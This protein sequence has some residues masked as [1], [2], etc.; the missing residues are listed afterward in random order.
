MF[1][2]TSRIE[3]DNGI[4]FYE[5]DV[6]FDD[7][8][9]NDDI[10]IELTLDYI[11]NGFGI[12]FI[13]SENSSLQ[14]KDEKLLFKLA[15]QS[16]QVYYKS[17]IQEQTLILTAPCT[18]V[19][20][21]AKDLKFKI[22]KRSN[23]Y[24]VFINNTKII[25]YTSKHDITKYNL[26]YYSN[27]NNVIKTIN[28]AA[29]IPYNWIVNMKNTNGGY[30]L[31]SK[32]SFELTQCK[33][34]AEIEQI[35]IQ[36]QSGKYYL[37]YES[38]EDCDIR[39]YVFYSRD[40]RIN[41]DEKNILL[42]DNSFIISE[43]TKVSL[44]FVGKSGKISKIAIT[45][46]KDNAYIRTDL[47][48]DIKQME[49]SK[50]DFDLT[51][52][53]KITFK[54]KIINTPTSNDY[55]PI[56]YYIV[57]NGETTWGTG[58]L[59]MAND[60][61][62]NYEYENKTLK[63]TKDNST[64]EQNINLNSDILSI[65]YNVNG[66]ITDLIIID[67]NDNET[68]MTVQNTIIKSVPG[69]IKS[70]I[71]VLDPYDSPLDISSSYRVIQKNNEDYYVFTNIER[72]YFYVKDILKRN[73]EIK[74]EE[75]INPNGQIIMYGIPKDIDYNLD[76]LMHIQEAGKDDIA[77][78]CNNCFHTFNK[79][80]IEKI[81]Y[82]DQDNKIIFITDTLLLDD[83]ELIVV[84]YLK[85]NSYSINY[86]YDY[87]SYDVEISTQYRDDVNILYDNTEQKAGTY[88]Y[89]NEKLYY[90][91]HI[92]PSENCYIVIGR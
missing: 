48:T 84:D 64:Y 24:N 62:Y 83:Y 82:I 71:V 4:K 19:K 3:S 36:L 12:M 67:L 5:K 14:D 54:G 8:K 46:A 22:T 38:S 16:I 30:I 32:D 75:S 40:E 76:K 79:S 50:I 23:L 10:D 2:A 37:K 88:E 57:S 47:D 42:A 72:E 61:V 35:N 9:Y 74:L 78:C 89:I 49:G 73:G 53:K 45:S 81:G 21:I 33:N 7:Y 55:R 13:N 27:K 34:N 39:P 90:D 28:I 6:L 59:V 25:S 66:I 65:F 52:I 92:T 58:D 69:L 56:D 29:Q 1:Q 51:Q 85:D 70:P 86:R 91:S 68:N 31:F 11:N 77:I 26:A 60:I 20:T 80:N 18:A 41:D 15:N 43:P 63:I 87:N 17:K 44:K